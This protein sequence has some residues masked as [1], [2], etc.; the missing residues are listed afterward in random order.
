M[1]T[2]LTAT[3][4]PE[5]RRLMR[6]SLRGLGIEVAIRSAV[7]VNPIIKLATSIVAVSKME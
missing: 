3:K 6:K 5:R 7:M 2:K 1:K 4:S